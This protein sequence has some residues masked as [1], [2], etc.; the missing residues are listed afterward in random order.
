MEKRI[1]LA[2]SCFAM[3]QRG[4]K[5]KKQSAWVSCEM[6]DQHERKTLS[7]PVHFCCHVLRYLL[8]V[9]IGGEFFSVYCFHVLRIQPH[10]SAERTHLFLSR[11]IVALRPGPCLKHNRTAGLEKEKPRRMPGAS[12]HWHVPASDRVFPEGLFWLKS[13]MDCS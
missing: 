8:A 5:N 7:G 13:Y 3:V 2:K 12:S 10:Q 6:D 4:K 1:N 11:Q 9:D